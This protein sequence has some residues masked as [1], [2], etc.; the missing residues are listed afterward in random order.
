MKKLLFTTALVCSMGALSQAQA[1]SLNYG[2]MQEMFGE[3]VT[4]S[5][6]GSPMRASDV[7]LDMTIITAEDIAR[8]PATEI[9]DIL[10][11]YAGV[12]V[13]QNT[14]TD[15][16]VGIRGYNTPGAERILV[17]VNGR[18]V[19]EDYYGL[20]NW[21][22]IPV[23]LGE[24]RQ[25]EIVRGPNTA[26]FGF[27]ATSGVINIVTHNPLYDDTDYAEVD[28]GTDG[29]GRAN[30]VSTFQ[31]NGE[32]GMRVSAS[33]RRNDEDINDINPTSI[34]DLEDD[35]Y[36]RSFALDT[37]FQFDEKTQGR[38]EVSR[39]TVDENQ[40][41]AFGSGYG[42]NTE[43]T[44][45]RMNVSSDTDWGIIDATIY[46][47]MVDADYNNTASGGLFGF[48]NEVT[49][50]QLSNTVKLNADHTLRVAAEYRSNDTDHLVNA[51]STSDLA[52]TKLT[53][54]SLSSLWY[55]NINDA[56]SFS[57]AG[58][59][60]HVQA[61]LDGTIL[62]GLG[63]PYTNDQYNNRYDEFGYNLG[64]V[65]KATDKDTFRFTVAKGVDLPS[66]FEVGFQG[67]TLYANPNMDV[68]DVHDFQLGYER[69]LD[70]IDAV[71]KTTG[72]YQRI[73]EQQGLTTNIGDTEVAGVE[74]TLD[75]KMDN[76]I[77][78]GVN[79]SYANIKDDMNS[80]STTNYDKQ[81]SNHLFNANIGYSPNEQWSYDLFASYESEFEQNRNIGNT[82]APASR[83][84]TVNPDVLIDAR[85]A[86]KPID[87]LTVSLNGRGVLG[88]NE[89]SAYGEDVDSQFFLRAKYEF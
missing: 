10:R 27:N 59:Y 31:K 72:F 19:F 8:Y 41:D 37:V 54:K 78:W 84:F 3:P 45:V 79:Y 68:S 15:Y 52:T 83:E 64:M 17:L 75:G 70:A 36:A 80:A 85:I 20:V 39:S 5:A 71:F 47:N 40:F 25:I 13:R 2:M 11:H 56:L 57:A 77:R 81:N 51:I 87:D 66:A 63:N 44:S 76:G 62:T 48:D 30:V 29:Y 58:R 49:V 86:Y 23:E 28:V 24:I 53:I 34:V 55:W 89:Q 6:N 18:Q 22:S 73:N 74:V 38:F 26:L 35:S 60:D 9:P 33:G 16:S 82:G 67:G 14:S 61:D 32:F 4:T 21:S 69:K 50:A 7:P 12:S 88:D 42:R 65:Y 43:T 1:Q 46:R